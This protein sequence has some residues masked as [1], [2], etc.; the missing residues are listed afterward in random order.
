M[1]QTRSCK[2]YSNVFAV[3]CITAMDPAMAKL[4]D[5]KYEIAKVLRLPVKRQVI[6]FASVRLVVSPIT[7]PILYEF[8]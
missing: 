2:K 5:I 8:L 1:F 3:T 4:P 7:V 6:V